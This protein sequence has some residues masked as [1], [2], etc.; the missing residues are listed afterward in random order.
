MDALPIELKLTVLGYVNSTTTLFGLKATCK[1]MNRVLGVTALEQLARSLATVNLRRLTGTF[2]LK[3]DTFCLALRQHCAILSGSAPLQALLGEMY[4]SS[5]LDIFIELDTLLW[6]DNLIIGSLAGDVERIRCIHAL[7]AIMNTALVADATASLRADASS[8]ES[9]YAQPRSDIVYVFTFDV[10]R[11]SNSPA[12]E[13]KAAVEKRIQ[14]IVTAKAPHVQV[15]MFDFTFLTNTFDGAQWN[16]PHLSE[17]ALKRGDYSEYATREF[18]YLCDKYS[19]GINTKRTI[20][21]IEDFADTAAKRYAKY[22]RRGFVVRG[23]RPTPPW[24]EP[25]P[26]GPCDN[27]F[28]SV[29]F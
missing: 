6:I 4:S 15:S 13:K 14:F 26:S 12:V 5:D 19:R 17:V 28:C 11:P 29:L 18:A 27:R 16:I 1:A 20:D 7:Q 9:Y 21:D 10:T 8:T 23:K 22:A 3:F 25:S 24:F 2:H